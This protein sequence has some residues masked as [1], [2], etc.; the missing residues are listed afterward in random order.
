MLLINLNLHRAL[1]TQIIV[2]N[3]RRQLYSHYLLLGDVIDHKLKLDIRFVLMPQ[4]DSY[5]FGESTICLNICRT[6]CRNQPVAVVT[7]RRFNAHGATKLICLSNKHIHYCKSNAVV[8]RLDYCPPGWLG[9]AVEV[10]LDKITTR[11]IPNMSTR[12]N[13]PFISSRF[14]G[15]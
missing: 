9:F 1:E 15:V 7:V 2:D 4:T 3:E 13:L 8:W 12:K 14:M 10:L 5:Q 11:R 6:I